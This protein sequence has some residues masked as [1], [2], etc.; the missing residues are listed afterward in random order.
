M[1]LA[2]N[3]VNRRSNVDFRYFET[4]SPFECELVRFLYLK[5]RAFEIRY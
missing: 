1:R 3:A 2:L 5:K 4:G